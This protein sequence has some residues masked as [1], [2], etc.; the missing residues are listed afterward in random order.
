MLADVHSH[1]D[2]DPA[3]ALARAGNNDV[4]IVLAAAMDLTTS[5]MNVSLAERYGQVKACIG[6]H[7]WRA[8]LFTPETESAMAE[9]IK[10]GK[11]TAIS[12]TGVDV[13]RRRSDDFR[14]ELEPL[15]LEVQLEAFRAQVGLAVNRNLFLVVHDRGA[16]KE[17]LKVFDDFRDHSPR[18]IIHG[19][20]GS[21]DEARQYRQRGFLISINKRNIPAINP[22]LETLALNEI[23]LETDSN[24]PA[25]VGDVCETVASLKRVTKAEVVEATTENLKKLLETCL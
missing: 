11:V 21:V 5:R 12:E 24:E 17:I 6:V 14:T 2:Q 18:G 9:L 16:S 23:V 1:L 8:D 10:K 3:A 22:V 4:G 25:R 13:M 20:L 15:P 7:P 19:F